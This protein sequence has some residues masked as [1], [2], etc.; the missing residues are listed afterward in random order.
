MLPLCPY[1]P[2]ANQRLNYRAFQTGSNIRSLT[3]PSLML[4]YGQQLWCDGLPSRAVLALARVLYLDTPP[5]SRGEIDLAILS[6]ERPYEALA[7]MFSHWERVAGLFWGNPRVSFEHQAIRQKKQTSQTF[8][9]R[10]WAV[11]HLL[12]YIRPDISGDATTGPL[13]SLRTVIAGLTAHASPGEAILLSNL[14]TL[15]NK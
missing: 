7:W 3:N 10:A 15:S 9:W 4:A 14:L 11:C 13:P 6:R 12:D 8:I 1:L 5:P 2:V